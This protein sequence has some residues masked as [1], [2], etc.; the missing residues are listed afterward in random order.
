M[1]V[2]GYS[3]HQTM[4]PILKDKDNLIHNVLPKRMCNS[5]NV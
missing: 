1:P 2:I 3:T 4:I 5:T